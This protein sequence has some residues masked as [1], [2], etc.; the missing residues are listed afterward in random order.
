M[1]SFSSGMSTRLETNPGAS[2]TSTGVLSSFPDKSRTVAKVSR[3]VAGPRI[4]STNLITGTGLKKCMPMTLSGR[5]VN[6]PSLVMEMDEGVRSQNHLGPRP[7]IEIAKDFCFDFEL[8][9]CGLDDKIA[10][11]QLGAFSHRLDLLQRGRLV[12]ARD[13]VLRHLAIEILRDGGQ[14]ALQKL[15][16]HVA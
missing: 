6:A 14:P 11:G 4:T 13:L 5:L 3:D 2:F 10:V 16:L 1:A 9:G 15:L 8:L 7:P 12:L